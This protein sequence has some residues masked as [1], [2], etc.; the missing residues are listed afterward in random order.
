MSLD[1]MSRRSLLGTGA[2]L[3]I[4]RPGTLWRKCGLGIVPDEKVVAAALP[5]VATALEVLERE[6]ADG[7]RFIIGDQLTL[8]DFYISR[9]AQRTTPV[10]AIVLLRTKAAFC[11]VCRGRGC[12]EYRARRC[13][14]VTQSGR[15]LLAG[16]A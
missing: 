1:R 14:R 9:V 6:L 2:L 7:R 5:R 15:R 11:L 16:A 12:C 8:A 10:C 13:R 4:D 3:T